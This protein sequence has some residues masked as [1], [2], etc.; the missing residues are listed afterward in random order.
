MFSNLR[1][2]GRFPREIRAWHCV[3]T[4][5]KHEE[6]N[7]NVYNKT[8]LILII[9]YNKI[10]FVVTTVNIYIQ[11]L[12]DLLQCF[13]ILYLL[14][15]FWFCILKYIIYINILMTEYLLNKIYYSFIFQNKQKIVQT[16]LKY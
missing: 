6:V 12:L 2:T 16:L 1:G 15:L 5:S 4:S 11:L 8:I 9:S 10:Q 7:Q 3:I 13:K 14:Q